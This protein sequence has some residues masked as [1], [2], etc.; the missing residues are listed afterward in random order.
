M[1]HEASSRHDAKDLADALIAIV[2]GLSAY[3][4]LVD[5]TA[6]APDLIDAAARLFDE[7]GI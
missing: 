5:P 4:A 2:F 3:P 6:S 7:A 1:R